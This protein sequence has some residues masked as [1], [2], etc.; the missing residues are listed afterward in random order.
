MKIRMLASYAGADFAISKGE[1]TEQFSD[2]EAIRMIENG[3][4]IPVAGESVERAVK[5]PVAEKRKRK[6]A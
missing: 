1:E 5:L 6:P 3:T 4:A 2:A